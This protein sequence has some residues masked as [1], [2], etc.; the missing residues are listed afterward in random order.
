MNFILHCWESYNIAHCI[1]DITESL[2]EVKQKTWR[3]LWG[4][5]GLRRWLTLTA[6]L[7]R[8][9]RLRGITSL[10]HQSEGEETSRFL[11]SLQQQYG[12][13]GGLDVMQSTTYTGDE[14]EEIF[15][16]RP[17]LTVKAKSQ[18]SQQGKELADKPNLM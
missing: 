11:N 4:N 2:E 3:N 14:E 6:V 17:R 12:K 16:I 8:M 7:L 5:N 9:L 15:H 13:W 10:A 18:L 1:T